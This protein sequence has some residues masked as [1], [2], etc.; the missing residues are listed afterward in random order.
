MSRINEHGQPIGRPLGDWTPPPPPSPVPLTGR[1]VVLEPLDRSHAESLF[2]LLGPAPEELWTYMAFG[3]FG[4]VA[5]LASTIDVLGSSPGWLPY[6]ITTGDRVAGFASY[7]RA[8]PPAGSIEIGSIVFSPALQR[9]TPATES[10]YLMIDNVFA[11]GY[12]RCEWKCDD[13]NEPS[14]I[15]ATRLGFTYE[16]TFRNATHYKGR[17]RDTAWYSI[18]DDEW[19]ALRMEYQRWLDPSNFDERGNQLTPLR[20]SARRGVVAPRHHG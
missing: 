2:E 6:A 18:T 11:L 17:S 12:R 20:H 16:G 8:D 14:R 7:L 13:L 19:P 15:A 9:T 3:P 5:E 4:S 1:T 10:M